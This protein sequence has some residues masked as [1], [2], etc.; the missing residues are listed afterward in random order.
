MK[1]KILI[2]IYNDW[3][4][5]IKILEN[6]NSEIA[7]LGHDFSVIIVNDASTENR[8]EISANLDNSSPC[9]DIRALL[10]VITLILFCNANLTIFFEIPSERPID[11]NNTSI[12]F[13]L[14]IFNGFE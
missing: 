13:S 5:L 4:S 8:P 9:F 12:F 14:K 10:G 6:I 7:N 11:S 3:Q 1:V 2:P